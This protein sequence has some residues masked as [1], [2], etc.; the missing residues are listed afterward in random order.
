ML[1]EIARTP[2]IDPNAHDRRGLAPVHVLAMLRPVQ[3]AEFCNTVPGVD[4][5]LLTLP[6]AGDLRE[7]T[8]LMLHVI[9]SSHDGYFREF[10]TWEKTEKDRERCMNRPRVHF[11]CLPRSS[12]R[13]MCAERNDRM[14]IPF[15]DARGINVNV[16]GYKG[17][18]A[19]SYAGGAVL[20]RLLRCP[21]VD[22]NIRNEFGNTPIFQR[23][24]AGHFADML[25]MLATGKVDL[26][27][28]N[29]DGS[30][31]HLCASLRTEHVFSH[32]ITVSNIN[33]RNK[34][35]QTALHLAL[36]NNLWGWVRMLGREPAMNMH[37]QD[38]D[39]NTVL[40][41][42]ATKTDICGLIR[43]SDPNIRNKKG[44]T[45]LHIAVLKD[46]RYNTDH[47]CRDTRTNF[48]LQDVDGN[49]A[50][51]LA[52]VRGVDV[53][54]LL[55]KTD[56]S[57]QNNQGQTVFDLLPLHRAVTLRNTKMLAALVQ[58]PLANFNAKDEHGN[59]ALHVACMS[60]FGVDFL[61]PHTDLSLCNHKGKRAF[62]YAP[63]L[64]P[65]VPKINGPCVV[66][67]QNCLNT[68][69]MPCRHMV[70]CSRCGVSLDTCPKCSKAIDAKLPVFTG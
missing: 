61:T 20:R 11:A 27:V 64:A 57:I 63:K 62:D 30:I 18:T 53:D 26:D 38:N 3:V 31:L 45:A 68:L 44:Q 65:Y 5:N 6:K 10:K 47:L 40:H 13:R 9:R 14:F 16:I 60:G 67:K 17:R 70:A 37:A 8:A 34:H 58:H 1:C 19:V 42:A 39:G 59:T 49:T 36:L 15:L 55:P 50:L 52:C 43:R 28:Q 69:F 4:V 32:L 51:H 46:I 54:L 29:E 21:D 56:T 24:L 12:L 2:G 22:L 66:C 23:V 48:N 35:G 7:K 41:L 33:M 25:E